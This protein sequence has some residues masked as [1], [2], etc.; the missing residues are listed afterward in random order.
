MIALYIKNRPWNGQPT[1][2]YVRVVS[3]TPLQVEGFRIDRANRLAKEAI[4]SE[5]LKRYGGWYHPATAWEIEEYKR[6]GGKV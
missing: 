4:D 6:L 3:Q 5:Y 2:D 1:C